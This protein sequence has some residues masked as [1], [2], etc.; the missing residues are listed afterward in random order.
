MTAKRKVEVFSAGCPVCAEAVATVRRLACPACDVEVLDMREPAA[1][2]RA[3]RYG[4]RSVP[5]V[6]VNGVVAEC[7]AGRGLDEGTLREAGL[8]RP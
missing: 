5:A 3:S 4:L 8:G 2:A 6:V 7:C 1:A